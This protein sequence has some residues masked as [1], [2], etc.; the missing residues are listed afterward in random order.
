MDERRLYQILSLAKKAGAIKDGEYACE[1]TIRSYQAEL[2]IVAADASDNTKKKFT[3]MA[4]FRKIPLMTAGE[5]ES[6]GRCIG[7]Q[8]RAVIVV[9]DSGFGDSIRKYN[10]QIGQGGD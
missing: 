7:K 6:L 10:R 4:A 2:V 8:E 9:T 1:K 5:K 3:D